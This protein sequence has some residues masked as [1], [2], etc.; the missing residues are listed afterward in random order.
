[1]GTEVAHW[2]TVTVVAAR[3]TLIISLR[4]AVGGSRL[5]SG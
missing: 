5:S 2:T 3:T 1:L 4:E